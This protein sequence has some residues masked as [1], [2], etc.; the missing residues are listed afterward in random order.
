LIKDADGNKITQAYSSKYKLDFTKLQEKASHVATMQW[1]V[2]TNGSMTI[3]SIKFLTAEATGIET[4]KVAD[5]L[6]ERMYNLNG[7]EASK[8]YKGIVIVNGKKFV[9]R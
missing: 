5:S 1:S 9:R 6:P 4:V 7:V 8:Q 3:K 2:K